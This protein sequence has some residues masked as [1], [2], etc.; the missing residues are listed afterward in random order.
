MTAKI[1]EVLARILEG[2][3]QNYSL[4][5]VNKKLSKD[6]NLDKQLVSA[7]FSWVFDRKLNNT[8]AEE[9]VTEKIKSFRI[10]TEEEKNLLGIDNF[11]YITHLINVGLVS[12]TD[13]DALLNQLMLFPGERISKEEINWLILFSLVDFDPSILPG[14]RFLL[15]S[16]DTIN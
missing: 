8:E 2:L 5:E 1:V 11:N 6:K 10:L 14:S 15:Y 13:F 9:N 4:E 12:T 7:A 16:S 3:S